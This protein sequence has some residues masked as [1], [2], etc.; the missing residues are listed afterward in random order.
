MSSM[1]QLK[2]SYR[3]EAG[4]KASRKLDNM[5]RPLSN[6][7]IGCTYCDFYSQVKGRARRVFIQL[8]VIELSK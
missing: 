3:L 2:D 1:N 7:D 6:D 4:A 5:K 8:S